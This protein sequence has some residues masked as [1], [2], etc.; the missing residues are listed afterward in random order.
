MGS[1]G[2]SVSSLGGLWP[3]GKVGLT[4]L[5]R[6]YVCS[7]WRVRMWL[8]ESMLGWAP[9]VA[10]VDKSVGQVEL[11]VQ[12]LGQPGDTHTRVSDR[13]FRGSGGFP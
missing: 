13:S 2:F 5:L 12:V 1:D 7:W 3:F 4:W 8:F 6:W 9:H 10:G 11:C